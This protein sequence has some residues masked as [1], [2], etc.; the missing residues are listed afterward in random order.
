MLPKNITWLKQSNI[1]TFMAA[2]F[3][4]LQLKTVILLV[5]K[6][7]RYI[8]QNIDCKEVGIVGS[9]QQLSLFTDNSNVVSIE[10]AYRDLGIPAYQYNELKLVLKQLTSIPV[11]LKTIDSTTG[12][13]YCSYQALVAKV[14]INETQKYQ[15][16]FEI[17]LDK[18]VALAFIDID[19]GFTK[20]IKEIAFNAKCKYSIRMYML[21]SSWQQKGGFEITLKEFRKLFM[22]GKKYPRYRELYKRVIKPAYEELHEN[23]D[24]WFEVAEKYATPSDTE[25]YKLSFKVIKSAVSKAEQEQLAKIKENISNM[26]YSHLHMVDRHMRQLL[27]LITLENAPG[28]LKKIVYL[29]NYMEKNSVGIGNEAEYSLTALLN[30]IEEKEK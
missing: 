11:E 10:L 28:V 18:D 2:D 29:A 30:A 12:D 7:Q 25:P 17:Q 26:C 16:N 14:V 8:Q 13:R 5:E 24:C 4:V 27:P 23:A 6:M 1:L 9:S 19:K 20:F 22:L 15:R 21:I 3:S